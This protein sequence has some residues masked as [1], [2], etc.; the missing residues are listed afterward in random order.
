MTKD[1]K[2][3]MQLTERQ[4]ETIEEVLHE[5]TLFYCNLCNKWFESKE[6]A[7][8]H[9]EP[10]IIENIFNGDEPEFELYCDHSAGSET[11]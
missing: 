5:T 9:Y 1:N 7:L 11:A 8:K 10:R 3:Q 2:C 4:L 6:E